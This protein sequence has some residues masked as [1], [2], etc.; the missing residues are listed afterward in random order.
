M[1]LPGAELRKSSLFPKVAWGSTAE[2][3]QAGGSFPAG[4]P[5]S[6][7]PGAGVPVVTQSQLKK[8]PFKG[9]PVV[10]SRTPFILAAGKRASVPCGLLAGG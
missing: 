3:S 8:E 7:N 5:T 4:V 10:I 9:T 1:F 6:C 2:G